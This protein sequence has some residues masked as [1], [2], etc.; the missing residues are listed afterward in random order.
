MSTTGT[1]PQGP[2]EDSIEGK[3]VAWGSLRK[4][5]FRLLF[6]YVVLFGMFCMNLGALMTIYFRI[7]LPADRPLN[8]AS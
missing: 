7:C 6:C 1:A 4:V 3:Q 2:P 8:W 5:G